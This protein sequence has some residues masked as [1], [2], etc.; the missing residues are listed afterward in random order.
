MTTAQN[1]A[2][3]EKCFKEYQ[4]LQVEHLELLSGDSMPDLALMT[5]NRDRTFSQL[6]MALEKFIGHVQQIQSTESL[7]VLKEFETK[8]VSIVN[9]DDQIRD[10]IVA[11]KKNLMADLSRIQKGKTAMTG[12]RTP[13][14]RQNRPHVLSMNT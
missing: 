6:T 9:L 5:R 14:A 10:K 7:P 13:G 12:Y 3:I 1:T 2:Y 8:F 11:V 4:T